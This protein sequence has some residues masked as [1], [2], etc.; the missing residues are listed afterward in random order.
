ML[1]E[2]TCPIC[3]FEHIPRER[4]SCPQCD[5]DL[6]CFK[7]LDELQEKKQE[8][9]QEPKQQ[10][11]QQ[12]KQEPKQESRMD[13]SQ[14]SGHP[15]HT[16]PEDE[17]WGN[18]QNAYA[19]GQG[20]GRDKFPWMWPLAAAVTFLL[21]MVTFFGYLSHNFSEMKNMIQQ[22]GVFVSQAIAPRER[23]SAVNHD[24][25]KALSIKLGVLENQA[26]DVYDL[27]Q[28]N[29]VQLNDIAMMQETVLIVAAADTRQ[30]EES[31]ADDGDMGMKVA[32]AGGMEDGALNLP[33]GDAGEVM[34]E[35][36]EPDQPEIP[37]T[38]DEPSG[39]QLALPPSSLCFKTYRAKENDTLWDISQAFYGRGT[40]YPV[41]LEHNPDLGIFDISGRDTLRYLCDKRQVS[42]IYKKI[43]AMK[44]N[45]R[46]WKYTLR[47]GDTRA[48]VT[49]RYCPKSKRCFVEDVFP[50]IGQTIGI[51]LE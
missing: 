24:R 45:R 14:A 49:E 38:Q 4:D 32:S 43:T 1:L 25:L 34:D 22:N 7:L 40:Y 18:Q 19:D 23:E 9:K 12:P 10:P 21:I 16:L 42:Q 5:S 20:G 26:Q 51:F 39:N 2:I 35:D 15:V 13:L 36:D 50:E 30:L 47:P 6:V 33:T 27:L 37:T 31:L 28:K 48:S 44:K 8:K 3:H 46:Y 17:T 29:G 41:L 11:K